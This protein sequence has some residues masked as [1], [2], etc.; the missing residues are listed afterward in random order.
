MKSDR[1]IEQHQYAAKYAKDAAEAHLREAVKTMK[2]FIESA[3]GFAN[4]T[5]PVHERI[6]RVINSLAWGQANAMTDLERAISYTAEMI[7]S[8]ATV[9]ALGGP[10]EEPSKPLDNHPAFDP[11][12]L[13]TIERGNKMISFT[14]TASEFDTI[15]RIADRAIKLDKRINRRHV[16]MDITACHA[17]GN[18]LDL[19]ELL[20]ADDFNFTHDVFGITRY[21]D[22]TTGK[23]TDCFVPRYTR[24]TPR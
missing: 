19:E 9:N 6:N 23:L 18:P 11:K 3:E 21:L 4:E 5:G 12:R 15:G 13:Q 16:T 14:A 20:T 17:N 10:K 24:R 22:R 1:K 2:K 7:S 8:T